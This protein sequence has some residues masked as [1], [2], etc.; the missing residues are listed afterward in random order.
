MEWLLAALGVMV[1]LACPLMM[2]VC[3]LGMRRMRG[4]DAPTA[5]M[6]APATRE[7]GIADLER[8]IQAIQIELTNLRAEQEKGGI[9]AVNGAV[10]VT[11]AGHGARKPA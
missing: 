10:V 8:Q 5:D 2:I 3:V 11:G 6:V 9:D 1:F 7:Q 4:S